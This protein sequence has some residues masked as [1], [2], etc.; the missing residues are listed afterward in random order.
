M[1]H[2]MPRKLVY[3]PKEA[4][5]CGLKDP[6]WLQLILH[7]S[8]ILKHQLRDTPS[9]ALLAENMELVQLY[10]GSEK[11]LISVVP[12]LGPVV[13]DWTPVS[14]IPRAWMTHVLPG[15]P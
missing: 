6:Y 15:S 7:L 1:Q 8:A 3:G 4:R 13:R 11:R 10:V 2:N 12:R 5:G 14:V 9:S